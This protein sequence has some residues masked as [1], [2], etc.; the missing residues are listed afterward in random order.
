[1]TMNEEITRYMESLTDSF[2]ANKGNGIDTIIQFNFSDPVVDSWYVEI[3]KNKC[4]ALRGTK[5]NASITV[6]V[7]P[8]IFLD[9]QNGK[10]MANMAVSRGKM[11][12]SGD[13]SLAF[14]LG[15]CFNLPRGMKFQLL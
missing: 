9:I 1:M 6:S 2:Q 7:D 11:R 4:S 8:K 3:Q 14:R 15:S 10:I 5:D 13:L 12:L